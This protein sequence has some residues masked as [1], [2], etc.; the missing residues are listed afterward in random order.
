MDN[1]MPDWAG[2]G[3]RPPFAVVGLGGAGCDTVRD[4]VDLGISSIHPVAINTDANHLMKL[5]LDERI[6]IGQRE[7][8][9]RGSGGDRGGVLRAAADS[10]EEILRRLRRFEVI[11]LLAGLGG[12]TGSALLP[13]LC[14]ELRRTDALPIP[15]VFLPFAVELATNPSRRETVEQALDELEE[16]GGLLVALDNEKLRRLDS[17]SIP[18]VL[19]FRSSYLRRLIESL[20]DM[21]NGSSQMNVDLATLRNHLG[22]SGLSTVLVGEFHHSE[23]ER[24]VQHAFQDSLLDFRLSE[25]TSALIHLDGGSNMT[26]HT[27]DRVIRSVREGLHEPRRVV[28]GTRV[29][30]QHEEVLRLTAVIGGLQP[31]TM[32]EGLHRC[33]HRGS[34]IP[35]VR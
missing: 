11:F 16:M 29:R 12:G 18:R 21:V 24:L 19:R 6:L 35:V 20:N 2:L 22:E 17:L 10:R 30:D 31:R 8:R 27:I 15:V 3:A 13:Y 14:R 1:E 26:L 32:R 9:G 7:L 4:L 33:R 34:L 25:E 23:P 5:G 28:L